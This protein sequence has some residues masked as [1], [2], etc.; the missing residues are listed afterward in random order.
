MNHVRLI[1]EYAAGPTQLREAVKD[2]N[3]EQVD[4][5]PIEGK[6]STRQ[7]ICHIADFE[8]VYVD[9]MKRVIAQE[10]PSFFGGD[11]NLF[12]SKLAYASRDIEEELA[13]IEFCR[14]HMTRILRTL[15][16]DDFQRR[17]HHS[18]AGPMTLHKLLSNV[19]VHIP[20]HLEFIYE[21]RRALGLA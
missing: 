9:R 16:P 10:E 4:A 1:E 14:R 5:S 20:H 19:S 21:K 2:M 15:S 7:V 17:G 12:A 11:P 6:W 8:P 13:L 18:E 3:P